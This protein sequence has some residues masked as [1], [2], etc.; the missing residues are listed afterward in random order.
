MQ[1]ATSDDPDWLSSFV[2]SL[3][4]EDLSDATVRGYRYDLR[5]FLAWHKTIQGHPARVEWLNEFDLI[6]YRQ[7]MVAAGHARLR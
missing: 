5:H 4:R 2:D 7:A 1:F 3:R 6:A